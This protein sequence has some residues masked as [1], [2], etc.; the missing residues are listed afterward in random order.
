MQ[1]DS[2]TEPMEYYAN[3]FRGKGIPGHFEWYGALKDISKLLRDVVDKYYTRGL[4]YY[5]KGTGNW[6]DYL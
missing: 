1:I 4:E 6:N 2:A 5:P 3:K